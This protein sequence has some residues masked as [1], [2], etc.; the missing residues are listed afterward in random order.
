MMIILLLAGFSF[1]TYIESNTRIH[2]LLLNIKMNKMMM[3]C[4]KKNYWYSTS[5]TENGSSS[6]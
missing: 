4:V 5:G 2:L 1:V 6:A 3:A